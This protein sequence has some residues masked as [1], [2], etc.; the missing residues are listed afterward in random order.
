MIN[1]VKEI[2]FLLHV[3]TTWRC[4]CERVPH[5]SAAAA[6]A[7]AAR[8]QRVSLNSVRPPQHP[9][10]RPPRGS[11]GVLA[12]RAPL[13]VSALGAVPSLHSN[14]KYNVAVVSNTAP[15]ML[16]QH[17]TTR[18]DPASLEFN[19]E[20]TAHGVHLGSNLRAYFHCSSK[21]NVN[22]FRSHHFVTN[23]PPL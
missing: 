9:P 6:A 11:G 2:T 14:N 10:S 15:C 17:T 12:A 7:A 22:L 3:G 23:P 18:E 16:S 4:G 21:R 8:R 19:T 20:Q 1:H 13:P 5:G